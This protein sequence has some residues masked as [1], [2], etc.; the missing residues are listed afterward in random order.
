MPA[1]STADGEPI[2]HHAD[3]GSIAPVADSISK[4]S[5]STLYSTQQQSPLFRLP[6][7]VRDQIY[8][9]ICFTEDGYFYDFESAR[10]HYDADKSLAHVDLMYTCKIAAEELKRVIFWRNKVTFIPGYSEQNQGNYRGLQSKAGRFRCLLR[11]SQM[12]KMHM[13][14]HAAECITPEILDKLAQRYP[15]VSHWFGDPLQEAQRS[16]HG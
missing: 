7:E 14:V 11:Y 3:S 8:D 6:R 9:E 2:T 12:A 15:G 1:A 16:I 4:L 10:L 5:I 13:L